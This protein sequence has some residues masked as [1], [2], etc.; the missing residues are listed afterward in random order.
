MSLVDIAAALSFC[1]L[2]VEAADGASSLY[3]RTEKTTINANG[4]VVRTFFAFDFSCSR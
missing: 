4:V 1:P 2:T 3:T